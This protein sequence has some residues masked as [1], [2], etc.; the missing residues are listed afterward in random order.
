MEKRPPGKLRKKEKR[1]LPLTSK[2]R[3]TLPRARYLR[4][5]PPPNLRRRKR[6]KKRKS[7]TIK[8]PAHLKTVR[9]GLPPKAFNLAEQLKSLPKKRRNANQRG[10]LPPVPRRNP[11]PQEKKHRN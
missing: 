2:R 5:Q 4:Q 8:L 3:E 6:R 10:N 1:P 11:S 9:N 7:K